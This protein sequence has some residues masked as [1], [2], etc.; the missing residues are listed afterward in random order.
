MGNGGGYRYLKRIGSHLNWISVSRRNLREKL[1]TGLALNLLANDQKLTWMKNLLTANFVYHWFVTVYQYSPVATRDKVAR[2]NSP[3][4]KWL[5]N[6]ILYILTCIKFM[7]LLYFKLLYFQEKIEGITYLCVMLC[8]KV[9]S[10]LLLSCER[11]IS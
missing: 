9:W 11:Y 1:C 7:I 3:Q 2:L 4:K 8:Y 5:L 10:A 6:I